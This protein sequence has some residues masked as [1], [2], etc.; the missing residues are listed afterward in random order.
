MTSG[1]Y[2]VHLQN[3]Q[4]T[5]VTAIVPLDS[6]GNFNPGAPQPYLF[7][8]NWEGTDYWGEFSEMRQL[9]GKKYMLGRWYSRD[10]GD[11]PSLT[12]FLTVPVGVGRIVRIWDQADLK[13]YHLDLVTLTVVKL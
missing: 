1:F 12:D 13:S 5:F 6:E 2:R 11:Y 8:A 9:N 7:K 4:H 10:G 3:G